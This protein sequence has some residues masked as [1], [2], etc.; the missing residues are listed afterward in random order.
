MGQPL[1]RGRGRRG[2]QRRR[3]NFSV[4]LLINVCSSLRSLLCLFKRNAALQAKKTG[5][6]GRFNAQNDSVSV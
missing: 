4:V 2:V 6:F 5:E 3:D 1:K